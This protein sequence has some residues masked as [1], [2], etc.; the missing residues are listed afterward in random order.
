MLQVNERPLISTKAFTYLG[1]NLWAVERRYIK[2]NRW[3]PPLEIELIGHD[4]WTT[5]YALT[6]K[7]NDHDGE[8]LYWQYEAMGNKIKI[9][10]S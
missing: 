4:G 5:P 6:A 3:N 9:L 7:V 8:P 2:F 1:K 10:N